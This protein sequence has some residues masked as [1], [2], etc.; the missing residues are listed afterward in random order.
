MIGQ[1]VVL[2]YSIQILIQIMQVISTMIV[3]RVA[4][5]SVLGVVAFGLAYASFFKFLSDFGLNTAHIRIAAEGE[6]LDDGYATFR[7]LKMGSVFL[8][9]LMVGGWFLFQKFI[10]NYEFENT[11][12]ESVILLSL[13]VIA[14]GYLESIYTSDFAARMEQAKQDI[15][16]FIS[17]SFFSVAKVF[18]VLMGGRAIGLTVANLLSAS[19]SFFLLKKLSVKRPTGRFR[20]ALAKKYLRIATPFLVTGLMASIMGSLDT[21]VLQHFT[22]SEQVGY[23]SA[24]FRIGSLIKMMGMSLAAIMLPLFTRTLKTQDF[25]SINNK[26]QKYEKFNFLFLFP[27]VML[28]SISSDLIIRLFLGE[29][30]I[31][32]G[33]I[34]AIVNLAM[35]LIVV[36]I[37]YSSIF[38]ASG[39]VNK[40]ILFVSVQVVIYF[41]LLVLLVSP[42]IYNLKGQGA[43]LSLF[44]ANLSLSVLFIAAAKKNFSEIKIMP[45]KKNAVFGIV[46]GMVAYLIYSNLDGIWS[47]MSF[48]V[49]FLPS[50]FSL[51]F[52]LGLS[53]FDDWKDLGNITKISKM[54]EYIRSEVLGKSIR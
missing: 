10:L 52:L 4:G 7:L 1:R 22:N 26:I 53:N 44:F 15:P 14:I 54:K 33:G 17:N 38:N 39:K 50:F 2:T 42:G 13:L 37:P 25:I 11:I 41:T 49:L 28:A 35:F 45:E 12:Q 32:S 19:L 23:Y 9:I 8:F 21:I 36:Y 24:S 47:K 34:L 48:C 18:T 43:A 27:L 30:F 5:P 31:T 46:F 16:H 51:S 29:K 6:N 40:T 3:A 20:L